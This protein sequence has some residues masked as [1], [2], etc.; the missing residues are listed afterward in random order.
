MYQYNK[1]W[2]ISSKTPLGEK[3]GTGGKFEFLKMAINLAIINAGN[4]GNYNI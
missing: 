1:N 4:G 2:S 3:G